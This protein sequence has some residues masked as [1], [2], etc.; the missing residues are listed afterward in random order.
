[1]LNGH[2]FNSFI[3]PDQR[4]SS[5]Y[6]L[7]QFI[8]GMPPAVFLFLVGVTLAFLMES[9][10]RQGELAGRRVMAGLRRAGYLFGIAF[11]F[12][13]Q[14]WAFALPGSNWI[15]LFKVDVLNAMGFAVAVFSPLAICSTAR[16]VRLG[17]ILGMAIA[18]GAPL[19]S[20]LNWPGS[21]WLAESYLAPNL[22]TFGFFPWAAFMAFGIS[23]G[24]ILRL[25]PREQL[26]RLIQW[27]ALLGILLIVGAGL[28][29]EL[30]YSLYGQSDYWLNGP[31]LILIKSGVTLLVLAAAYLWTQHGSAPGWSW[32][33]QFG[34]TS[35]LVY[36]VHTE[37]VY[38]RW[39]WFWKEN[40]TPAEAAAASCVVIL[41][42]LG[43]SLLKTHWKSVRSALLA[44]GNPF[45]EP[46]RVP[47]D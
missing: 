2:V 11:L 10:E 43:L 46:R 12:R 34:T 25:A 14:L 36:W 8:G 28:C 5:S 32:M 41:F 47:G 38:G 15:D 17:L 23:A 6:L 29:S 42:M 45:F 16:R 33:R 26:D 7:T 4:G 24:S 13:L 20:L 44:F 21:L 39:L 35:L 3:R 9:R 1:M 37:I 27:A 30:P 19:V 40:L 22:L 18:F 31:W